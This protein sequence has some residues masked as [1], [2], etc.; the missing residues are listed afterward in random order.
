MNFGGD[1]STSASYTIEDTGGEIATGSSSSTNY[2]MSAGYQQMQSIYM[3]L[4]PPTNVTLAPAIG[5]VTG[6]TANGST[7][8]TVVTDDQ[9]GYTVTIT[10]SSSPAL[11]S[12]TDS[13]A[14]YVPSGA[15]PDFTFGIAATAS[16]FAFSPEGTDIAQRYK[17]NGSSCNAGSSDTA[18]ACWDGLSTSPITFVSRSSSNHPAG[19]VTTLKF[20]AAS[21]SSHIQKDGTYTATTTITVLPQ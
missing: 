8:F 1:R 19:T 14:D 2:T 5:G 10:A 17:D 18:D 11:V 7:N 4:T 9:A 21:G 12:A 6:G 3:A 16:A 20:R 15:N 13:F